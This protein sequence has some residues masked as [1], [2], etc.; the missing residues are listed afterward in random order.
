L[1]LA[2]LLAL[3]ALAV[4]RAGEASGGTAVGYRAS[5]GARAPVTAEHRKGDS[6]ATRL[7]IGWRA[8]GSRQGLL[9]IGGLP[10]VPGTI[11]LAGGS[12]IFQPAEGGTPVAY[13]LYRS[14]VWDG[15]SSRRPTV[16]LLGVDREHTDAVYLFHLDGGV[17][18]TASP[19][20][21]Q[22]LVQEPTRV[23]SLGEAWATDRV[24]LVDPRDTVAQLSAV[25][26]LAATAYADSMF[27][28]FGTPARPLGLVGERGQRAGRLGEFIAS[29]DSISLSPA[30][31]T[32]PAQLRHALAH[33]LAHR[34]QRAMPDELS[35]LWQGVP[36]IGDSLRYG[37]GNEQEHQAEAAAFAVH[38]LQT[39]A[40]PDLPSDAAMD[41][42]RAYERLVPGTEI[43]ARRLVAQP[44]YRFHPLASLLLAPARSVAARGVQHT[45]NVKVF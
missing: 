6:I 34:W 18:E 45:E 19:G 3:L 36:P 21:L 25:R 7:K 1:V 8:A 2:G 12:L 13:P 32:Q 42:L 4:S 43:M 37:F 5:R 20:V 30:R 39:T 9:S 24:A 26:T 22:E 27:R 10:P 41:L 15:R 17:L 14:G 35:D 31:M 16:T 29:R 11:S 40:A 28:L 38:F 33:E 44:I 23:D